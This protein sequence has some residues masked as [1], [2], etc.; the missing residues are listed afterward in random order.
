MH[1]PVIALCP[2]AGGERRWRE[3]AAGVGAERRPLPLWV[4]LRRPIV[5]PRHCPHVG[6]IR[7]Q[8]GYVGSGTTGSARPTPSAEERH[9]IQ[10]ECARSCPGMDARPSLVLSS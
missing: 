1:R 9:S 8:N 5:R 2:A 6:S 3:G 10:G 4:R 7:V